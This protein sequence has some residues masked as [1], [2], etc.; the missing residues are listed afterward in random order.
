MSL[1]VAAGC[2]RSRFQ[3]VSVV[4]MIQWFFH[5]I[6]NSTDVSV[7]RISPVSPAIRSRG[8]TM[9]TPLDARTR[10]RPRLPDSR[11]ISSVHTPVALI[12]TPAP[13]RRLRAGLDVP[14]P[15]PDDP[16]GL[17]ANPTT[18]VD[19]AITAPYRGR[20]AGHGQGVP[21]VVGL[22]VVVPHRA[23][24]RVLA[25]RRAQPQRPRP[26]SGACAAGMD[27]APPIVS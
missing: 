27:R 25:Q 12:T 17:R 14:H 21:G 7:R 19:G 26:G 20:R 4:P 18:W 10:N 16:V 24:Q 13:T 2:A 9:C 11:W 8:T 3:S 22:R 1:R 5:G 6:T 23:D 15:D